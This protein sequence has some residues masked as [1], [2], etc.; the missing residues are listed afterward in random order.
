MWANV[1]MHHEMGEQVLLYVRETY[2]LSG[3]TKAHYT[4]NPDD[5]GGENDPCCGY[6]ADGIYKCG[7]PIPNPDLHRWKS[8][9]YMPRWASRMTLEV[10][11]VRLQKLQEITEEDALAEGC[12]GYAWHRH[13]A[14]GICTDEGELP[15]EEFQSL[16]KYIHGPEAW[17]ENP[18]VIAL[19]FRVHHHN[20]DDF[21]KQKTA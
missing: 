9:R 17:D 13:P 18:E 1:K 5:H 11:D 14:L 20:M 8:Y 15:S 21:I 3:I 6:K 12:A 4:G 2:S 7:K 10:T 16:W 19:T